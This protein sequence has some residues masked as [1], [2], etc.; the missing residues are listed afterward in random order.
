VTGR[1]PDD[2]PPRTAAERRRRFERERRRQ[3]RSGIRLIAD[4]EAEVRAILIRARDAIVA[5]LASG[6]ASEFTVFRLQQLRRSVQEVLTAM[7]REGAAALDRGV[8]AS[9]SAGVQLV[10]APLRAGGIDVTPQLTQVDGR[11]LLAMREF[12]TD[13]MKAVTTDTINRVNTELGL[14]LTGVVT[15]FETAQRVASIVGEGGLKR[16]LV[17]TR[18]EMGRAYSVAAQERM[19]QAT[20]LV[21]ELQKQWRRSGKLHA[22]FLHQ[23]IDGQVQ[24]VDQPFKLGNGVKLMHPRDP[25][26]PPAETVNCGCTALP[27]MKSW[28]MLNPGRTPVTDREADASRQLRLLRDAELPPGTPSAF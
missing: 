27:Y 22:R 25:K 8:V 3:V 21:P 2:G 12:L 15:P 5:Q 18:T 4:T 28:A 24:D 6:T 13:R 20:E 7:E 11:V 9:W 23:A 26:A 10:D 16:A 19:A 17:I 14:A 1:P